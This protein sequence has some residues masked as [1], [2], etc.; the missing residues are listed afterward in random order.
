L[1][2]ATASHLLRDLGRHTL[3]PAL[4]GI[5]GTT[6]IGFVVLAGKEIDDDSFQTSAFEI[7]LAKN[8]PLPA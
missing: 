2:I 6:P 5:K 8:A 3:G 1:E 4:A 7:G